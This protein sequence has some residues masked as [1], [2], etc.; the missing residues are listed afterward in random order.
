VNSS[1]PIHLA[2]RR[3]GAA[4][5]GGLFALTIGT[6]SAA[7]AP[8][9]TIRVATIPIDAGSEV[10][11]GVKMGFFKNNGLNVEITGLTSGAAVTA[12]VVGG[13]ADI[14]Q[15]NAVSI[16]QAHERGI[17][18][19]IIAGANRYSSQTRQA[20]I[21]VNPD[22]TIRTAQ[23]L[24]GKTIAVSG[25]RGITEIGTDNWVDKSGGDSK[26]VKFAD[27]PFTAMADALA[28]HRVD[29]ALLSQPQLDAALSEKKVRVIADVY[30]A[31]AKE[32]LMGGWFSTSP[33]VQAHPELAA[34]FAKA[35]YQTAKWAN[36]HQAESAVILEE[37]SKVHMNPNDHRVPF[38]EKLTSADLQ[39]LIDVCAKYG[40]LKTAFPASQIVLP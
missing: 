25:V 29:A 38:A 16:S 3:A 40:I 33:W 9:Q 24:N 21:V 8:L 1:T 20:A 26:T 36:A 18:V 4:L 10:Y 11:Y 31:I 2:V 35:M 27:M 14:G 13:A 17:P 34:S 6:A 7:D 30:S 23:D 37:A 39:P 5:L 22:S 19:V 12:A 32:F 28:A 15:S